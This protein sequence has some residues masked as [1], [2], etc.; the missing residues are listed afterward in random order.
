MGSEEE[1]EAD[2]FAELEKDLVFL[3]EDE[4]AAA[5]EKALEEYNSRKL[6]D[7]EAKEKELK[8]RIQSMIVQAEDSKRSRKERFKAR[9]NRR[10]LGV[11]RS[12]GTDLDDFMSGKTA[13]HTEK[14]VRDGSR[15]YLSLAEERKERRESLNTQSR[16]EHRKK[17][18]HGSATATSLDS[19]DNKSEGSNMRETSKGG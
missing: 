12:E 15:R 8:D 9:R 19:F 7:A 6:A 16:Q 11:R 14:A 10:K 2:F 5:R 13:L 1:E 4:G 17:M 3:S 18:K